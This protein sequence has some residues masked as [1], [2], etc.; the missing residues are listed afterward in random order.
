MLTVASIRGDLSEG[1]LSWVRTVS[2][3]TDKGKNAEPLALKLVH[4]VSF[5]Q[6]KNYIKHFEVLDWKRIG[7]KFLKQQQLEQ[8]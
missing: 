2:Q 4:Q 3:P 6:L 1:K 5:V 7:Q 8:Q